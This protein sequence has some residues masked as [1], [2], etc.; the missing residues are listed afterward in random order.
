[1]IAVIVIAVGVGTFI[2]LGDGGGG[3]GDGGVRSVDLESLEEFSLTFSVD[4][5][6][7]E[8][9]TEIQDI[10][11]QFTQMYCDGTQT[12]FLDGIEVTLTWEDEPD[13]QNPLATYENQPDTFGDLRLQ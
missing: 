2:L 10:Q 13:R 9:S 12:Y 11:V 3:G 1:M 5:H 4:S 7:S 8:G 6:L